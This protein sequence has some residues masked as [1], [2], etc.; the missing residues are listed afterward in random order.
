MF[1]HPDVSDQDVSPPD[2]LGL[3]VSRPGRFALGF[4]EPGRF[5]P[6]RF[7]PGRFAPD[8]FGLG[9]FAPP[10]SDQDVSPLDMLDLNWFRC[11][12]ARCDNR[13]RVLSRWFQLDY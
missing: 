11:Y 4:F 1:S 12:H 3:D 5:A 2:F 13:H 6:G 10:F 7:G 8:S 9:R